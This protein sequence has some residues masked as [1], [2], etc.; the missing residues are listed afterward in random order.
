MLIETIYKI[1]HHHYFHPKNYNKIINLCNREIHIELY[2]LLIQVHH[3]I[4]ENINQFLKIL[5]V[6]KI[7]IKN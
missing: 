4:L 6:V 2:S 3:I 5:A 7:Q 1:I